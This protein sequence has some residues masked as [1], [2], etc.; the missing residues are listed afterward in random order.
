MLGERFRTR[1]TIAMTSRKRLH[2][3]IV[4]GIAAVIGAVLVAACASHTGNSSIPN[5]YSR[6]MVSSVLRPHLLVFGTLCDVNV[7]HYLWVSD[8]PLWLNP[9]PITGSDVQAT[10]LGGALVDPFTSDTTVDYEW[11]HDSD[12]AVIIHY[13]GP[14]SGFG[15][16]ETYPRGTGPIRWFWDHRLSRDDP[17]G[18]YRVRM[19]VKNPQR[20]YTCF[21]TRPF[22][23]Q[24]G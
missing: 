3:A 9:P 10:L 2:S 24:H 20:L 6:P 8:A 11:T 4:G 7:Y 22:E 21:E 18:L 16:L 12:G 15:K 5:S 23:V 1:G 17:D 13:H 19:V 14:V